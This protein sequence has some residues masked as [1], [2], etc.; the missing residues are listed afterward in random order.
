MISFKPKFISIGANKVTNGAD[1]NTY[2]QVAYAA[3]N[4][5]A[6][7]KPFDNK[8]IGIT[9]TLPGHKDVVNGVKF[10]KFG[11]NQGK[12]FI[13]YSQDKTIRIW[14]L[15]SQNNWVTACILKGHKGNI[16]SVALIADKVNPNN[17]LIA[18]S[19][20]DST[21][22]I[23]NYTLTDSENIDELQ[24]SVQTIDTTYKKFFSLALD[25]TYLPNSNKIIMAAGGT[26]LAIDI[27]LLNSNNFDKI[28]SLQ[29]HT[30]WVR[31]VE[32][33]KMKNDPNTLIL[34]SSSQD[35]YIRI[36]KISESLEMK[37]SN[38]K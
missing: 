14:K 30:D 34:A 20:T 7:F 38:T 24:E 33:A 8:N 13:S 27:Y 25:M 35:K 9:K 22:K 15:N 32:F 31:C 2:G 6:L 26:N 18:S 21:I 37:S 12:V 29:G 10:L 4:F 1:W 28:L 36:W 19:A 17:L 3:G 5:I 11:P 16:E 23:W